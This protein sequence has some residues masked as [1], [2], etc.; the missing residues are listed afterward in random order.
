MAVGRDPTYRGVMQDEPEVD[1]HY[2]ELLRGSRLPQAYLPSAM[3][4]PQKPWVRVCAGL[5]IAVFVL[6]TLYGV[7]LTYGVGTHSF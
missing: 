5:V 1:P 4:G 7:C 6:A 2:L 3:A